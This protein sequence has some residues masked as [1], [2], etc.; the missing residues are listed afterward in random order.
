MNRSETILVRLPNWV[1]DVIMATPALRAL[2]T[3]FPDARIVGL[4]KLWAPELLDDHPCF[5]EVLGFGFQAGKSD[6]KTTFGLIQTIR[7][8][9]PAWGLL[10]PNSFGSALLFFLARVPQRI[11]YNTNGRGLFLTRGIKT[12]DKTL[13]QLDY[14]LGLTAGFSKQTAWDR[15]LYF[16]VSPQRKEEADRLWQAWDVDPAE[17]VVGLNPGAAWGRS[18]R[19][20]PEYFAK[21]ADLFHQERGA[22]IVIFGGPEDVLLAEQIAGLMQAP[23]LIIAGKDNLRVLPALLGRCNLFITNDTGPMHIAE[24]QKVPQVVLFGPTDPR[25]TAYVRENARVLLNKLDCAPCF[26]PECPYGHHNCM[27]GI[28]PAQVF[29]AGSQLLDGRF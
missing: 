7:K 16:P 3:T 10:F 1:G 17:V 26:K 22:K 5:D 28:S 23:S 4:G 21:T 19:W 18:K 29:D 24:S 2:R 9:K 27:V 12:P 13:H 20:L 25:Q 15:T 6:P 11:G 14:F 8:R